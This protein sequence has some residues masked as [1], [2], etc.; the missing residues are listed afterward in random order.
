MIANYGYTDGSG[1][2]YISI[3]T[4]GCIDCAERPCVA[5]CPNDVFIMIEDDYDDL[6]ASV[7]EESRKSLKYICAECKPASESPPLPCK[8]ACPMNSI[9]HTW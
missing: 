2:Y 1:E 4:D 5:A 6:V 9:D 3:N 8:D 7:R